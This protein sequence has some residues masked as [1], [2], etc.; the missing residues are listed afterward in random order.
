MVYIES[1][2]VKRDKER[3]DRVWWEERGP[4]TKKNVELPPP[5]L[6]PEHALEFM[7]KVSGNPADIVVPPPDDRGRV[8]RMLYFEGTEQDSRV[9]GMLIAGYD[10]TAI[11]GVVGWPEVQRFTRKAQRWRKNRLGPPSDG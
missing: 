8:L 2:R 1:K 3:P 11:A 7:I 5:A 4:T 9:V 10:L 6:Q